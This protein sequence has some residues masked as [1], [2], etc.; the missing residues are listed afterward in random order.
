MRG[1]QRF[2]EDVNNLLFSG[3]VLQ[4]N[5]MILDELLNEVHVNINLL[6]PLMLNKVASDVVLKIIKKY[7]GK[8]FSSPR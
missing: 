2:S 1:C 4:V 5:N 7:L 6:G 8:C 3:K